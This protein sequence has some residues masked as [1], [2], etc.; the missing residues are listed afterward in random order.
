[1]MT[2]NLLSY[3]VRDSHPNRLENTRQIVIS[4]VG[5]D[6]EVSIKQLADSIVKAMDFKGEYTVSLRLQ[7]CPE[8]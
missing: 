7:G 8:S 1:M 6:E 2:L 3:Q 4:L 5:E